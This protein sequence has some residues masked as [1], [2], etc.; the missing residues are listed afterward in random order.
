MATLTIRKVP[1]T[2]HAAIKRLA[3][4]HH[5]STEAEVRAILAAIA[6]KETGQGFG[7]ILRA[8]WGDALGDDLSNLRDH[9]PAEGAKFG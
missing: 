6:A 2:V 4:K 8:R 7:Q 5:R 9:S 1:E 3:K